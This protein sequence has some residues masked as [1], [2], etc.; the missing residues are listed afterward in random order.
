VEAEPLKHIGQ[1]EVKLFL[2]K[3]IVTRYGIPRSLISDNGTQFKGSVIR[4][5]CDTY[6][7]RLHASSVGYPQGNGQAEAS[8]KVVLNGLK[9]RLEAAKG[10]WV[11]ELPSVLWA[12]RTTPRRS[13]GASP[14]SLAYGTEAVIPLEINFPTLRSIQED[15]GG[16]DKALEANLDF[17]DE[18]RETTMIHLANYQNTLSRHRRRIMRHR[19]LKIGD[20]VLRKSM[21]TAVNPR[22]GKLGPNWEGPYKIVST[23][24]TGACYLEDASGVPIPNPWNTHHLRKYYH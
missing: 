13:T 20:L 19:E 17:V 18:A 1:A 6:G 15:A 24:N 9:R 5:F 7:I 12:F 16:N 3:N 4:E 11:E 14:F 21:G 10:R 22:D 2:W 8:N 23:T